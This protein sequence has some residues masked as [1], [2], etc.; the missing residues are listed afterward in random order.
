M[1]V[2]IVTMTSD[3]ADVSLINDSLLVNNI[4]ICKYRISSIQN[5]HLQCFTVRDPVKIN[6]LIMHLTVF[7][8]SPRHQN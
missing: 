6:Q 1:K 3:T 5:R 2:K 4:S 8:T 7:I